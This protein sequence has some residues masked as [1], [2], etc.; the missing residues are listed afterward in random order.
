MSAQPALASL[1]LIDAHARVASGALTAS[2]YAAQLLAHSAAV[3]PTLHAF[4]HLDPTHVRSE[5]RTADLVHGTA[6]GPLHGMGIG[7]KDII[8]TTQLPTNC[9][10]QAEA[11]QRLDA[12]AICVERLR[13]A[14]GYVFAK[15][16]TTEFAFLA[17][18]ATVNPWNAAHTPGG[19]S[20]G[21]AAAV[22][23]GLVPAAIG[24]Q[25]NGSVIRPAAFCGVVGFKPTRGVLPMAGVHLFSGT[26]DT[27]GT[28]T[29]SVADAARL[30][31]VLAEAGRIAPH[32]AT[33]ARPPRIALLASFP[34]T[35]LTREADD[36]LDAVA[37][38]L[39]IAG[40]DVIPTSLPDALA[41]ARDV[42]RTIMLFEGAR[43]MHS[44]QRRAREQLSDR[45][46]AGL[47][48]GHT[49]DDDSYARAKVARMAML[50][51]AQD[52]MGNYDVLMSAPA[53]GT[54]PAGIDYTGDPSCCTLWSL[55]GVPAITLPVGTG[56]GG[57]PLGMQLASTPDSDDALL[58]VAA[59]IEVKLGVRMP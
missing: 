14:G 12:D 56:A 29:R 6:R 50:A 3:E 41:A 5:A 44:V 9:G 26:L 19:S 22:A 54:A 42:H 15:T 24:T 45:L 33:R 39:R 25:T 49:I 27:L 31:S 11:E 57:L 35:T 58:N 32:V 47:D 17:P 43:R 8:G 18:G 48:E 13:A 20:S 28:F 7:I 59:W 4:C 2:E 10:S 23:R 36:K 51:R 52:W 34:W 46:N 1:S 16:V 40:A 38:R 21:S 55:L 30:A 37:S 53:P